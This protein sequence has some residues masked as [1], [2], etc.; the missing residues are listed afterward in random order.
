MSPPAPVPRSR[1][2]VVDDE[3]SLMAALRTTLEE[4]GYEVTG[5]TSGAAGLALLPEGGFD[6]LVTDLMMPGMDGIKLLGRALTIDPNLAVIVMTGHGS[7]PTAVEAMKTGAVDYVLKPF[8][9]AALRTA[10]ERALVLRGLRLKN[11]ALEQHVQARTTQLEAAN[12]ELDAFCHSVSHDLRTPLR[13][14]EGFVEILRSRHAAALPPEVRRLVNLIRDGAGEMN[15]LIDDLLEF[16]RLGRRALTREPVDL[17]RLSR[18]AFGDLAGEYRGRRVDLRVGRLPAASGDPA[19]LRLVFVNLLSNALKF[20]GRREQAVIEIGVAPTVAENAPAYF[21]RD[22]GVGFDMRHAEELFGVFQ[23]LPE[24]QE[25]EGT[26]VGLAT[27]RRII[28]RH[29]GRIWAEARPGA[30]ATFFFT[31]PAPA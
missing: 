18:E 17:E 13:T 8:K 21:V 23:R 30:G 11:V 31:L 5:V 10:L 1:L 27:V 29:G 28:E 6:V 2:L 16:S 20:T 22:N 15:Q 3:A 25:F 19:L 26:G 14:I 9:L 4:E 12:Q 7:I 24:A